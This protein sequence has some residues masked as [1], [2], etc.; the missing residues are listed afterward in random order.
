MP[1]NLSSS[2][3][4]FSSC[5]QSFSASGSFPKNW[6]SASGGQSILLVP[7][8]IC[9]ACA[10]A[11]CL[12]SLC[13]EVGA[14]T[15]TG[16]SAPELHCSTCTHLLGPPPCSSVSGPLH[17]PD[18]LGMATLSQT[19]LPQCVGGRKD[20]SVLT[21]PARAPSSRAVL[22]LAAS[23]RRPGSQLPRSPWLFSK[24]VKMG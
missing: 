8:S 10:E 15:D 17:Q 9:G 6:L 24:C 23:G 14:E 13:N 21:A 16:S 5:S 3:I 11:T 20:A 2:V 18:A 12:S 19:P 4:P 1:S 7:L 22:A